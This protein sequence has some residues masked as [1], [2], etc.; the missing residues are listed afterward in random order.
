MTSKTGHA[1]GL[2]AF[3]HQGITNTEAHAPCNHG[4]GECRANPPKVACRNDGEL[5]RGMGIWPVVDEGDWCGA[6][7]PL[8][9]A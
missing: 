4:T 8:P 2:C 1:C 6:F 3:Y 7:I 9:D 5:I